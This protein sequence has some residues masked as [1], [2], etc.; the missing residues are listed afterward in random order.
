MTT[1]TDARPTPPSAKS[2]GTRLEV[3]TIRE[4]KGDAGFF[5]RIGT[6]FVNNDGSINVYLDALPLDGKLH[7][8]EPKAKSTDAAV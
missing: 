3:F 7:I 4:K 2:K 5:V 6:A 8:R 1:T